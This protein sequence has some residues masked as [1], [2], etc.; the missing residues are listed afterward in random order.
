MANIETTVFSDVDELGV[1]YDSERDGLSTKQRR[2]T[3]APDSD[4]DHSGELQDSVVSLKDIQSVEARDLERKGWWNLWGLDE[5]GSELLEN[6]GSVARD[7]VS[8]CA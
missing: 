6:N 5:Y 4:G 2:F 8:N 1:S 3:N 7:H